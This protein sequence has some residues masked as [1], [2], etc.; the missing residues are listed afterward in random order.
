MNTGLNTP[1]FRDGLGPLASPGFHG[2]VFLERGMRRRRD[3]KLQAMTLWKR[4]SL[5][6]A[7]AFSSIA[8]GLLA[9]AASGR[10]AVTWNQILHQPAAWYAGEEAG[11]VGGAVLTY[12]TPSGGW[13]KNWDMT[14]P[15]SETF[16]A[17]KEAERAPT[18]DNGATTTQ[19][20]LLARLHVAQPRTKGF[21]QAVERG[22]D[23]LLE[24]QYESGGWPQFYPLRPG[25]YTHI[26]FNDDAMVRVLEVLRD[27]ARGRGDLAWLDAKRRERAEDAVTCGVA[28]ILRCQVIQG[29]VKTVWCAQHDETTFAPAPARKFEP[30]SLSGGESVGILRFLMQEPAPSP[31][32]VAAVKAGVAWFEKVKIAGIRWERIPA[33]NLPK[34]VD[35]VATPDP[36]APPIWARFYELKTN[37]PIFIGR[38]AIIRYRVSDIEH[39]RRTGYAWY[40]TSPQTLLERDYPAWLARVEK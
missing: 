25:Y 38:D 21:R 34:G 27:T 6:R 29:G 5:R 9:G 11:A 17:L 20:R 16:R 28:C 24:S 35:A 7:V 10:A 33:P 12:Q 23:Y 39:E 1:S 31:E 36:N 2:E 3:A 14:T 22:I 30:A 15:L 8:I 32:L 4:L 13:P 19:I 26:T 18:I 40:V 37:R